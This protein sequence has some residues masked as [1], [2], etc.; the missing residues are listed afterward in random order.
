[1]RCLRV[2]NRVIAGDVMVVSYNYEIMRR[3]FSRGDSKVIEALP[4]PLMENEA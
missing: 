2:P 3:I 4:L 1:M